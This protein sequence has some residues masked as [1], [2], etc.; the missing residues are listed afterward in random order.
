[1]HFLAH[2]PSRAPFAADHVVVVFKDGVAPARDT[3]AISKTVLATL[4]KTPRTG[5]ARV[6]PMY[7]NDIRVNAIFAS[8]G[9]SKEQR[10]FTSFSR[11]Q[12]STMHSTAQ[13]RINRPSLNI[14]NAYR[15][16]LSNASVLDA[17]RAIRS[18]SSIAY[19]SPDWSVSAM[20]P[21]P[22]AMPE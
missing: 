20:N 4:R 14:A 9:V 11:S 12:L 15:V 1:S 2:A 6:A 17:V 19:V 16:D 21:I 10:L 3:M 13:S 8:L 22:R 5:M 18:Q 7:T